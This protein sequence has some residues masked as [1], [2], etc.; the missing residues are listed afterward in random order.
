MGKTTFATGNALT[1]KLWEEKLFRDSL[2]ESYFSRFMG[3]GADNIVQT[4]SQLEKQKGDK[5]TFGLRMRLTGAGVTDGQALE[6]AEEALT[7]Y[8]S[9]VTLRQYR[10]AVRDN[11]ALDRQRAMFSIDEESKSALQGWGSEKIDKLAF[12]AILSAPTLIFYKTSSGSTSTATASTAKTNLTAADGKITPAMVSYIKAYAKTGGN[13][14]Y[15]PLRP[16]RVD[17][18]EYYILLVH[19]DAMYDWKTDPTYIQT[20]REAE[21]RGPTNP[22]FTGSV[23]VWDGVIIH[24]HEN[25]T[26]ASDG[27]SGTVDWSKGVFMG[28]QA[29]VWAWGQRE[30]VIQKNFDYENEHGYAWGIIAGTA[31]PVFNSLDYG[32][33]GVYLAR[34]KIA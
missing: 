23:A 25:C 14:T 5:I 19:P 1:K 32:S 9:S 24:E 13:R 8:D 11:G 15:V 21:V 31:K 12:D 18:K 22:I 2:K 34:T 28:A 3:E 16:V 6:G 17:G 33:F 27:G 20:V 29:L 4:K 10:H 30:Q 26:V 7:T